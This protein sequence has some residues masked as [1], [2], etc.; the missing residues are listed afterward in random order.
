MEEV[1]V[2]LKIYDEKKGDIVF[3]GKVSTDVKP[4][5][6]VKLKCFWDRLLYGFFSKSTNEKVNSFKGLT[7]NVELVAGDGVDYKSFSGVLYVGTEDGVLRT[8]KVVPSRPCKMMSVWWL[9][10]EECE[11]AFKCETLEELDMYYCKLRKIPT[12]IIK[13][14]KLKKLRFNSFG[15][16]LKSIPEEIGELSNLE[17]LCFVCCGVG[18]L[19]KRLKE[20]KMLKSIFLVGLNNL[21]LNAEDLVV[22]SKLKHLTIRFCNNALS[23]LLTHLFWEMV[24]TTT[25]LR[26]LHFDWDDHI[27]EVVVAAFKENGSIVDGGDYSDK[28][29]HFFK[30]N[31]ENHKKALQCVLH[32]LAIRRCRSLY[33]YVPKEMFE[34]LSRMLWTT[35]C[36][37]EA[38]TQ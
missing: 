14:K 37:V 33:N 26:S 32:L 10:H 21:Q 13:M 31:K 8:R 29:A 25:D 4:H 30:R 9:S 2:N 38:W 1:F 16:E 34:M 36:D 15:D 22:F 35:R 18:S 5:E 20:L 11:K 7:D 12:E 27:Q 24:K 17:N 3:E 23:L 28:Y 6:L 19:P